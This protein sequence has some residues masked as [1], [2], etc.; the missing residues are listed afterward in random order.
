MFSNLND[1]SNKER[2]EEFKNIPS[3]ELNEKSENTDNLLDKSNKE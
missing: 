1:Y 3:S 2:K